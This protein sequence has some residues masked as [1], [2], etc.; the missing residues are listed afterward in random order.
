[1][2][3]LA[4]K[5]QKQEVHA[6]TQSYVLHNMATLFNNHPYMSSSGMPVGTKFTATVNKAAIYEP[7][8]YGWFIKVAFE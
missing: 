2:N 3:A 6:Y 1:M 4:D 5:V 8:I 7:K